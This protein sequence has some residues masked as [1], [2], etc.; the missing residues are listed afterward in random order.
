MAATRCRVTVAGSIGAVTIPTVEPYPKS[1]AQELYPEA[2][3]SGGD[4]DAKRLVFRSFTGASPARFLEWFSFGK[5]KDGDG[6]AVR[7]DTKAATP[8]VRSFG[9]AHRTLEAKLCEELLSCLIRHGLLDARD[10][11]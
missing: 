11:A 10:E 2:I 3:R 7:F 5:R 9:S 8:R 4:P 6:Y 1:L